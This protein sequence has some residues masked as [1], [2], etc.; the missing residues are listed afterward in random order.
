MQIFAWHIFICNKCTEIA[1]AN[2]IICQ[3]ETYKASEVITLRELT[4]TCILVE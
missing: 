1:I 4:Q 2:A 3:E